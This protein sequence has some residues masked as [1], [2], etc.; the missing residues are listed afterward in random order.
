LAAVSLAI[1]A[2][3]AMPVKMVTEDMATS[4]GLLRSGRCMM[5][6]DGVLNVRT[7]DGVLTPALMV[8][9]VA[10]RPP[11]DTRDADEERVGAK[12]RPSVVTFLAAVAIFLCSFLAFKAQL[13]KASWPHKH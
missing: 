7:R 9:G 3:Q 13:S 11:S 10:V 1:Q 5:A 2:P 8:G 4:K 12:S 6:P